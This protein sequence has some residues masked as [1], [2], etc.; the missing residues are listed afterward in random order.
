MTLILYDCNYIISGFPAKVHSKWDA[1]QKALSSQQG[2]DIPSLPGTK[3][4]KPKCNLPQLDNYRSKADTNYW[5][6][7]PSISWEE[8]KLMKSGINPEVLESLAWE[9]GYP[10]P[11]ILRDVVNDI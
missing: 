3:V 6:H 8:A 9:T 5:S 2:I 11:T 10:Y 7:W 4:F 1:H